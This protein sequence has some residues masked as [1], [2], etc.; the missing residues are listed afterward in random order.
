MRSVKD[1]LIDATANRIDGDG[2]YELHLRF[3]MSRMER[4]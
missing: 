4:R 2:I 3:D 1:M